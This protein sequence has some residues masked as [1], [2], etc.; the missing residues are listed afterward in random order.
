M[1]TF[2]KSHIWAFLLNC[3]MLECLHK[4]SM[5]LEQIPAEGSCRE[6]RNFTD[7]IKPSK[8]LASKC[9]MRERVWQYFMSKVPLNLQQSFTVHTFLSTAIIC[10]LNKQPTT[11]DQHEASRDSCVLLRK[12]FILE[13]L[14]FSFATEKGGNSEVAASRATKELEV[15]EASRKSR[16]Q[17]LVEAFWKQKLQNTRLLLKIRRPWGS[18]NRCSTHTDV[19]SSSPK[20]QTGIPGAD[21]GKG[22]ARRRCRVYMQLWPCPY[23]PPF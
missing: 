6:V 13:E 11:Q 8:G 9:F 19:P 12:L 22:H 17:K 1:Y 2:A 15:A 18:S 10:R 14:R 7:Q 21:T 16:K 3:Q 4:R 23:S 20:H 5:A